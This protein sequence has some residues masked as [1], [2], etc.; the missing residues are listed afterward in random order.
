M[1]AKSAYKRNPICNIYFSPMSLPVTHLL[2]GKLLMYEI[3]LQGKS[4]FSKLFHA[5]KNLIPE[6]LTLLYTQTHFLKLCFDPT[7]P[8]PTSSMYILTVW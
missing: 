6:S 3:Q 1:R 8:Q 2:Y 4:R 7:H 5:L